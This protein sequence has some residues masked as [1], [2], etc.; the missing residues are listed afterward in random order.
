M[1][2]GRR[3]AG[4]WPPTV[5]RS[6]WRAAIWPP[7]SASQTTSE[8]ASVVE[9]IRAAY[10]S[11]K[12]A[13]VGLTREMAI[14]LGPMGVRSNAVAPSFVLTPFNEQR[15]DLDDMEAMIAKYIA[16]TPLRRLI[17]PDDVAN[18]VAFLAS[19]RA[20]NITGEV[21]HVCAGSQMPPTL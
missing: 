12:A 7:R 16:V 15:T 6:S 21:I 18:A 9:C 19:E 20:R 17:E 2:S 5:S 3:S 11:S 1:A 8:K 4:R 13:L 14:E 10:V